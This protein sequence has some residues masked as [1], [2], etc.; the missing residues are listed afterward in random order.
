MKIKINLDNELPLNET[1]EIPSM[2][3]ALRAAFYENSKYYPQ[4]FFENVF[5]NVFYKCFF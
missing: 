3:I 2:I 5:I 4:L 1:I